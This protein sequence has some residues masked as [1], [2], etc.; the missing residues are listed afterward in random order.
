MRGL[1]HRWPGLITGGRLHCLSVQPV[2]VSLDHLHLLPQHVLVQPAAR[3]HT[4]H[5][6]PHALKTHAQVGLDVMPAVHQHQPCRAGPAGLAG[7]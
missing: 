3:P 7:S 4:Q 6:T 5:V 2:A 1:Q